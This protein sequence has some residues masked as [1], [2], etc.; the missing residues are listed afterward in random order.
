MDFRLRRIVLPVVLLVA[1][2]NIAGATAQTP[3]AEPRGDGWWTAWQS[4]EVTPVQSGPAPENISGMPDDFLWL[5]AETTNDSEID[6]IVW[7]WTGNR[8]LPLNGI[9]AREGMSTKWL[10]AFS[11]SMKDISAVVTNEQG[12][13]GEVQFGGQIMGSSTGPINGWPSFAV[14]PEPGCWTFEITATATTGEVY[15]GRV[16][17]PAVP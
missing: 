4:C 13:S 7:L 14:V 6:M 5:Q 8:P 9:Y 11:E 17:F 16:V 3:V 12:T 1:S 2:L 10:W 15:E